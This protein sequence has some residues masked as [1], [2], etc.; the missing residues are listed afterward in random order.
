MKLELK[1][2]KYYYKYQQKHQFC[3]NYSLESSP[4]H[5]S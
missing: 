1:P 3:A 2:K 4:G 5:V